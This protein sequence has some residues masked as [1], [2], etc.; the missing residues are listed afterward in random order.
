M[1]FNDVRIYFSD[2]APRQ[3][4][5]V[6]ENVATSVETAVT[7]RICVVVTPEFAKSL[8]ESLLLA[9]EKYQSVFG[10]LRPTPQ[11]QDVLSKLK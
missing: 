7:P 6:Q 1:S 5:A 4:A 8:G 3:M 11:S 10:A 9:V 2:V